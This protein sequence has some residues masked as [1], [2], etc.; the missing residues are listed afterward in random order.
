MQNPIITPKDFFNRVVELDCKEALENPDDVRHT[1]HACISLH[2]LREWVFKANLT[3]FKELKR[4][5]EALEDRCEALSIIRT[6]ANNAKHYPPDQ[7][8]TKKME[9]GTTV[10]R[11]GGYFAA[12]YFHGWGGFPEGRLAKQIVGVKEDGTWHNLTRA[13]ELSHDFW[14]KE[15]QDNGW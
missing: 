10:R 5:T 7:T 6:A 3:K 9:I 4:Y 14:Q 8:H 13:I 12:A 15:F 2:H 1:F 11:I